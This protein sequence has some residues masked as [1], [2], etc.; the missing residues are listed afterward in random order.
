MSAT[1]R[2]NT[3]AKLQSLSLRMGLGKKTRSRQVPITGSPKAATTA[4]GFTS[5][6]GDVQPHQIPANQ[7]K[8]C[9]L[10]NVSVN[11]LVTSIAFTHFAFLYPSL[12]DVRSR[13]GKPNGSVMASLA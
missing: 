11:V 9:S 6:T 5:G 13:S 3:V 2:S 1:W 10:Q 7:L 12:V 4:G 8:P